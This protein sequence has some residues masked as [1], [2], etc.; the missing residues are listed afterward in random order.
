MHI[1]AANTLFPGIHIFGTRI[2]TV[3]IGAD[4]PYKKEDIMAQ[5]KRN[6]NRN[7]DLSGKS[8]SEKDSGKEN[9]KQESDAG[10]T[11]FS[12]SC[13]SKSICSS[14][15]CTGL[16]PALPSSEAELEAYEEMYQ[17]CVTDGDSSQDPDHI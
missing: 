3:H 6:A 8:M 15:D 4:Y 7:E 14:T 1:L 13:F 17:F 9:R 16:I 12:D 5:K 2:F 11:G 10:K